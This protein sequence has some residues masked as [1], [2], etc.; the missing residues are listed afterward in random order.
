MT[1]SVRER[2]REWVRWMGKFFPWRRR[3]GKNINAK[4]AKTTAKNAIKP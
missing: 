2:Q 3:K 4:G 1:V